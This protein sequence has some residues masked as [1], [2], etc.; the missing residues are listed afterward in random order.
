MTVQYLRI[1]VVLH[2]SGSSSLLSLVQASR[3]ERRGDNRA[4]VRYGATG[5]SVSAPSD[6][7]CLNQFSSIQSK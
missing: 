4:S 5:P 7:I 6:A 2:R 3:E 1:Q